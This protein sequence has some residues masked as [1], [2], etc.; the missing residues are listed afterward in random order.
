MFIRSRAP[1]RL[2]L[3]GGGTDVSPYCDEFGGAVLNATIGHYA[4]ASIEPLDGD[5]VQFASCDQN[6]T[7]SY[8]SSTELLPD[9]NL[10]LLKNVHNY[11]VRHLNGGVPLHLRLTTRVDVPSGSGLGG[12]STLVVATLKAYAEWLN[13]P[14]DDYELAQAAFH[15]EREVAGLRGGRQDQYAAAFGGFNFMEFGQAGHVLVNPLRVKDNVLCE[16]EASILLFYTG[17][18]RASAEII[19]EQSRNVETG[20]RLALD[21]MHRVKQEAFRMKDA[22]LRGD[23]NLLHEVLRCSWVAKKQMS[24]RIVNEQIEEIY[25]RALEAGAHCARISGAGGGGFMF[26]LVDPMCKAQVADSLRRC[27]ED[28]T[29]YGCH[30]TGTGAQAWRIR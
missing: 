27:Q 19:A 20:N 1:L 21:A 10:D 23:F 16:L 18:S 15:I 30:F 22:L 4:Y 11:A 29:V 6:Q 14:I 8:R 9:G 7:S 26:F 17:A 28:G 2:G 24:S 5:E 12:S 3:A 25:A 13:Y